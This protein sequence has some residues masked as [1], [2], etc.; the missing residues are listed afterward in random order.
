MQLVIQAGDLGAASGEV[1]G[2]PSPEL[3]EALKRGDVRIYSLY[4]SI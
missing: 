2:T 1:F 3:M 4:Q